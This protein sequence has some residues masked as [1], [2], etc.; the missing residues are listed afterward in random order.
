MERAFAPR[1]FAAALGPA[2]AAA[3][4]I[5]LAWLWI[6]APAPMPTAGFSP[7][8]KLHC[9]SYAPFRGSQT[10][11]DPQT[12]IPAAQIDEDLGR[13]ARI[14]DCVRIYAV[15][16]GLE[17]VP[18]LAERHGLKVLLGVWISSV[19]E[20]NREQ[21]AVAVSLAKRH[22][23]T[24]R[25]IIVGNEVLLRKE[26]GA[27]ELAGWIRLVRSQV[28]TPVTYADV[29]E[30]WLR[31]AA[32]AEAVDFVTIH[33]LP[34]WEDEPVAAEDAARHVAEVRARVADQFS[35]RRIFIGETGWPSAG[36]MREPAAA[37]PVAQAR[38]LHELVA[39]S[40]TE[41]FDFNLIEAFDQ[42]WKRRLEGTV[43]GHWGLFTDGRAPKI[44]WGEPVSNHPHAPMQAALG[45]LFAWIVLAAPGLARK[46]GAGLPMARVDR[47]TLLVLAVTA[48]V[49]PLLALEAALAAA[50]G[51]AGVV[52]WTILVATAFASPLV[53]SL[54]IAS[55]TPLP[56]LSGVRHLWFG[57]G[58]GLA[59][60]L[61]IVFV[62]ACL[63]AFETAL[64]LAFEPR[65][66]D[67]PAAAF[68]AVATP[69]L[70]LSLR[71]SP[72]A[73]R[74]PW[75]ETVLALLLLGLC[76]RIAWTETR[77]NTEA[78]LLVGCLVAL[79]AVLARLQVRAA[80]A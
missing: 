80:T 44:S 75:L 27:D 20:R 74:R 73:G 31:N 2:V 11:L 18:E 63:L 43:G 22:P 36:R 50:W 68:A 70:L 46:A 51:I 35:G 42:P 52:K 17:H 59:K 60:A 30:F 58:G 66:R 7:P 55:R 61:M 25:A 28:R 53:A 54:A 33:I 29:W 6:G 72:P 65:Y 12:R 24:V 9:V 47:A 79:A 49:A 5:A 13:L 19:A 26:I 21:T 15:D 14:A 76:A 48:G 32:L 37:T 78:M 62:A 57:N 77:A 40:R 41:G 10:P 3:V 8:A 16:M 56:A 69:L 39:L 34:Y 45:V 38:V 71:V 23:D 64:G 67:L 4:L 1:R